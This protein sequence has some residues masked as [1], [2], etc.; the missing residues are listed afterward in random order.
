MPKAQRVVFSFDE[1]S[2]EMLQKIKDQATQG[3]SEIVVR[4][5]ETKEERVIV[6]PETS[7]PGACGSARRSSCRSRTGIA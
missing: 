6:V 2:L 1:T 3:F 4:D 7:R 5:P